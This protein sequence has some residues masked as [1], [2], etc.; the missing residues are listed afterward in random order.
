MYICWPNV[1]K[2]L[3]G[4]EPFLKMSSLSSHLLARQS[5]FEWWFI[6]W[7]GSLT[8]PNHRNTTN[9]SLM[10]LVIWAKIVEIFHQPGSCFKWIQLPV[11]KTWKKLVSSIDTGKLD[12][13]WHSTHGNEGG[14]EGTI[15]MVYQRCSQGQVQPQNA[16]LLVEILFRGHVRISAVSNKAK[17]NTVV[18]L[19]LLNQRYMIH[20]YIYI[21][22][23]KKRH[24]IQI[25]DW[26]FGDMQEQI[27]KQTPNIRITKKQTCWEWQWGFIFTEFGPLYPSAQRGSI[28]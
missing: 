6:S 11:W 10:I 15:R 7:P 20:I 4:P 12:T 3:L 25:N 26:S 21:Y 27:V 22:S 19:I 5:W 14:C 24:M 18:Y 23:L 28:L 1:W 9:S 8:I 2:H 17:M 13:G 16:Q